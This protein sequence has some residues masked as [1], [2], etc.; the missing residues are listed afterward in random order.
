[1][2][3][4]TG[5]NKPD[6]IL[7]GGSAGGIDAL[8]RLLAGLPPSFAPAIAIVQHIKAGTR[9][10]LA[11]HFA[12]VT[13]CP[14]KEIED[15]EPIAGGQVYFAPADYHVLIGE[16]RR[17]HLS[18][19]EPVRYAR[20]SIDVLFE[21]AADVYRDRILALVLTGANDDGAEGLARV[22]KAGGRGVVQLPSEAAFPAMP[23]AALDANPEAR[24]LDLAALGRELQR[25]IGGAP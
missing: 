5:A 17:F 15:K 9:P 22:L 10:S 6:L 21:T 2:K 20:P 24:A 1:M 4:S 12:P 23:Q 18:T 3:K 8:S 7:I 25:E 14:V 13:A 19:E 16:D 11:D